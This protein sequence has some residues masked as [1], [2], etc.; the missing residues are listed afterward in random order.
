MKYL[1]VAL[2][3]LAA[4]VI[5]GCTRETD[6]ME[7]GVL[8]SAEWLLNHSQDPG[9]VLLHSGTAELFDTLHIP[10]ARLIDPYSFT[11]NTERNRNEMPPVDSIV[12][13]LRKAGVNQDSRIVLYHEDIGLLNR[14]ARV[15]LTLDHL[16]LGGQTV[17]LS[18]GLT[19]WLEEGYETA[20]V[21][22]DFPAGNFE[23][24]EVKETFITA[25]ELDQQRWSNRQVLIDARS[26]EEY[27]GA[28]E[29]E[30]DTLEGGHIEGAY[31]LSFLKLT[32]DDSPYLFKSDIELVE[33]FSRTEMDPA[34]VSLL[35]C[36]SGIKG[37]L[38]YLTARHLGYPVLLYDGSYEEWEE[39]DM[40]VTRPVLIPDKRE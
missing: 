16:G 28:L 39:L 12:D 19:A 2:S 1:C 20:D 5:S 25:A 27:Y 29:S 17:V 26:D 34:K 36:N 30:E 37:S 22:T 15:F 8:V 23:V 14:T 7:P 32:Y 3:F 4:S 35:Y 38:N 33:L 9:L 10:G 13:L 18:G 24:I 21:L 6:S 11:V 31:S 40:P